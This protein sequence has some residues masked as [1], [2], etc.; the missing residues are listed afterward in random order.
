M[1]IDLPAP[2][3]SIPPPQPVPI[4]F[5]TNPDVIALKS[6]LSILM[7]QRK[8]AEDDLVR[9]HRMKK[10]GKEDPLGFANDLFVCLVLL[11]FRD[12][13]G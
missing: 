3:T 10:A 2:Q 5:E 12:L 1:L 8:K 7:I 11:S 13:R 4:D 9:L 6:T